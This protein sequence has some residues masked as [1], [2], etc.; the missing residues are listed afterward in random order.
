MLGHV[1]MR[2][3]LIRIC[4]SSMHP[5]AMWQTLAGCM[6]LHACDPVTCCHAVVAPSSNDLSGI[7]HAVGRSFEGLTRDAVPHGM[8]VMIFGNGTGGGFHF[9]D[10]RRGDK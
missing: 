8:G 10:V 6:A 4:T 7:M 2:A 3:Q 9:R 1:C 5:A